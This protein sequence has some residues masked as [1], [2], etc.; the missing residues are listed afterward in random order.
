MRTFEDE[1]P[2]FQVGEI[3]RVAIRVRSLDALGI[4]KYEDSFC[5]GRVLS[6]FG[7]WEYQYSVM[8]LNG[9]E[10]VGGFSAS[11]LQS[12]SPLEALAA[13]AMS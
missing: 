3:V 8:L 1:G 2:K 12:L 10:E 11:Y 5:Y 4:A 13:E 7:F 6:V 9:S